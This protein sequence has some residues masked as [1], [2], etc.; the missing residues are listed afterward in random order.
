MVK[1]KVRNLRTGDLSE[2]GSLSDAC[3]HL[4]IRDSTV[5]DAMWRTKSNIYVD[6]KKN[7]LIEKETK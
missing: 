7:Y 5:R 4:K 1:V 6:R 3:R 2:F